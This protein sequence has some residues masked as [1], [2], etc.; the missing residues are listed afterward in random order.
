VGWAGAVK[1]ETSPPQ[2]IVVEIG[3][4]YAASVGVGSASYMAG[5]PA[6][7]YSLPRIASQVVG[8]T[9]SWLVQNATA[10]QVT[11]TAIY[12]NNQGTYLKT[13][14]VVLNGNGSAGFNQSPANDA[15]VPSGFEG[16]ISLTAT[17]DVVVVARD[18]TAN[19]LSATLAPS[20]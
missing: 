15:G 12:Y 2:P 6:R 13:R 1:I 9:T 10:S 18:D 14:T 16:S 7:R 11:V 3:S 20:K 17:G 5:N 4:D 19:T 8:R